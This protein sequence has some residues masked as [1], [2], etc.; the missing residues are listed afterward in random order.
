[1]ISKVSKYA[2]SPAQTVQLC[3]LGNLLAV[4]GDDLVVR[5]DLVVRGDLVVGHQLVVELLVLVLGTASNATNDTLGWFK[6][7]KLLIASLYKYRCS[8]LHLPHERHRSSLIQSLLLLLLLTKSAS[9]GALCKHLIQSST[10]TF[11]CSRGKEQ[12]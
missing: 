12:G 3:G 8:H 9:I 2:F 1:M 6:K 5:L 4:V 7:C 11:F 10:I